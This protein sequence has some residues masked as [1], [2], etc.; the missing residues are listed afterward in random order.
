MIK[1]P[2]NS[3]DQCLK[4][5]TCVVS[6]PVSNHS[7]EFGGPKHLGPE[8]KRLIENQEIIDDPSVEYC[9]L[10]GNCDI[11]CPEGVHL[12]H[13]I[14]EGKATHSMASGPR[15]RDK[16]LSNAELVG[17][18]AST[19]APIT[20]SLMNTKLVRVAMQKNMGIHAKRRFPKYEFKNFN[21][22]YKKK[23]A[24]TERKVAYFSGCYATY[25]APGVAESFVDVMG[26]NGIEVAIPDQHCCGIPMLANGRIDQAKKNAV[27]NVNHLLE[28]TR[29]GYDV[30]LTCSSCTLALKKEYITLDI[31]GAEELSEHVYDAGEYLRIL[32][33]KGQMNTNLASIDSKSGYFAPCHMKAQGIGNPAMDILELI[34]NYQIQDL[35]AGCCGQCGTFGFKEEKFDLSLKMGTS[36]QESVVELDPDYTVT[37]C[38]MCKNQ[39][40]QMTDKPVKHPMQILSEAY[41]KAGNS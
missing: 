18:L 11:S 26:F 3:F 1:M 12:T 6:C 35:A 5:N 22:R 20:N 31:D 15:F 33:E 13:F 2:D 36:M 34:P 24:N 23:T 17:K 9:T 10:C 16:I 4:C 38:G 28:Y 21:R 29:K 25:N 32:N 8:L 19:F 30:V 14:I 41:Q 7:L 39:L 37:E 27:Y 40:D